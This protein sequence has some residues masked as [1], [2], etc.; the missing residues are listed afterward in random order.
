MNVNLWRAP[1]EDTGLPAAM[2][3]QF[4]KTF[5]VNPQ[6]FAQA[7]QTTAN[8]SHIVSD[9]STYI[10]N[11]TSKSYWSQQSTYDR[12]SQTGSDARRGIVRVQDPDTGQVYEARNG[13]NYYYRLRGTDTVIRSDRDDTPVKLDVT[14]PEKLW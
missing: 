12:I 7:L 9:T 10:S 11:L 2:L 4:A 13:S 6:W 8:V 5:Q 3:T 1:T 14:V